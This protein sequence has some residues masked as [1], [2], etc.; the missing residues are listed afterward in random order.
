MSE[1]RANRPIYQSPVIVPLGAMAVGP[2][3]DM[4]CIGGT[5]APDCESGGSAGY[6]QGSC[7]SGPDAIGDCTTGWSPG[8]EGCNDGPYFDPQYQCSEG[9]SPEDGVCADGNNPG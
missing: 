1:D 5:G 7:E 3:T 8:P 9:T 4:D 2:G 6:P